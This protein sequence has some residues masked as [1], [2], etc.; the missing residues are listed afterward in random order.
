MR[1][2][3]LII[4]F[5][6]TSRSHPWDLDSR[7][8]RELQSKLSNEVVRFDV[9]MDIK[10]IA[11]IDVSVSR[12]SKTGR[13]AVVVLDYRS[14][15]LCEVSVVE[16]EIDF[17]YIPGL[18][19]FREAPLALRA[20]Q[21][22]KSR[23]DLMMVDGQGI[24]HPRRFGIASHLGLLLDIPSI[25]CAKSRLIGTHDP[26]PD[27]AGSYRLLKEKDEI[28]GAAVRTKLRLKPVY[29]SIGHRVDLDTA[30]SLVLG[31]CRGYR[32]P[33]PTRLAHMAAGG[34]TAL[35]GYRRIADKQKMQ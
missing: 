31:C 29:V 12:F 21:G 33:Q 22:L 18:L 14:Q 25:G 8:A 26:L 17:P 16:G 9:G 10:L 28:I 19:S 34:S 5:M 24:A 11:G 20:W 6:K 3:A 1:Y 13:A 7:Q 30:V 27:E 15:E 35:P 2:A 4:S 23:P 32:L